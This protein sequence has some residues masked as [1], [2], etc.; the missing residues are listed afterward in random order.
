M[1][2]STHFSVLVGSGALLQHAL[3]S[4]ARGGILG[5]APFA[6][7]LAL[8][9]YASVRAGD[10]DGATQSQERLAPLHTQ[11]VSAFGVPGVKAA[12]DAIGLAGGPLRPPLHALERDDVERVARASAERGV[13]RG[14]GDTR[15]PR[16]AR[17]AR[18]R[19]SAGWWGRDE[20]G[21][22][23]LRVEASRGGLRGDGASIRVLRI[24][25]PVCRARIGCVGDA[26]GARGVCACGR[27]AAPGAGIVVLVVS[28]ATLALVAWWIAGPGVLS[29]PLLRRSGVNLECVR[30]GEA[31][32]VWLVAHIDS[33]SQPVPMFARAA[34][35]ILLVLCGG[36]ALALAIEQSTGLIGTRVWPW[37][38]VLSVLSGL[39]VMM[40]VVGRGNTGALDNASGVAA[41][42]RT[43][44]LLPPTMPIGVLFT[45]GEELALAGARAW[46][47]E[48]R[49]RRPAAVALNCDSVDD[50]GTLTVMTVGKANAGVVGAL[51]TAAR[52]AGE[53][54]RVMPLLP[55][56]LTDSV[57]FA[58]VGWRTVTLS[59]GTARTLRRI[60]SRRDTLAFLNGDGIEGAARLLANAAADLDASVSAGLE[61]APTP[62]VDSPS[63]TVDS[64]NA[65]TTARGAL[66]PPSNSHPPPGPHVLRH[67]PYRRRR[68]RAVGGRGQGKLVDVLA[69]R[70][71]W[72]VRYQGGANA[73]HTV[74]LADLAFVLHQIPSGI[75]HPGVRCAIGNGVVLDPDTL[76]TEIDGL[77]RDGIDVEGRLY[78]SDRAHLVLPYHKLVDSESPASQ[79]IG[80]TGRGIGPAYEDKVAR[81]GVRVLDLRSPTRL[82][83]L[84]E[85][86]AAHARVQLASFGS[87]KCVDVD[88]T[89]AMLEQISRRLLPLVEDV[90]ATIH[91]AIKSGAAILLEGAQGSL[92]DVDHGT[93][94]F[95]TSSSTTSGGAAIGA[96][97]APTA[98]DAVLGVVK[99]YTTRVGNGPLPT[100]F[101]A[102]LGERVRKLGNEFGAT[103]GRPRRCGWF[104]AVV[105]QYAARVNGLTDLAVTKLDVLD[106]LDRLAICTGYE[107]DGDMHTDF[108]ADVATL[109][110]ASPRYE[111]FDGWMTST[112]QARALTDLPANAR[113]Y[114]DR[115][116]ELIETPAMYVSVGTRRDQ[117]IG[118]L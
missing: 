93:Y 2:A 87:S 109:E 111:W 88:E 51:K 63:A 33:K 94:P 113:R 6:P 102:D 83:G 45:D 80:T 23:V 20:T 44:A 82:R 66:F 68:G 117:I 26:H 21:A 60:H 58:A 67:Q 3:Q 4:G 114:L 11:I 64:V 115:I 110:G 100:E 30:G 7:A 31:P 108:P 74:D 73:G 35:V 13:G 106:T 105:V 25:G 85:R 43:V 19:A 92:L 72:V 103:T 22:R 16:R 24:S 18:S 39:P 77:V 38:A 81:R 10:T 5:V 50:Q 56:V 91:R 52:A 71:D 48:Q 41:V 99:A 75:L 9:V 69:E 86:G 90:G 54:L 27:A 59:R 101:P 112:V 53:P 107:I 37:C 42:L 96:G 15:R 57:A 61:R 89:M 8:E 116:Q 55:G 1:S 84:V 104:D 65:P 47:A 78:V 76:F 46:C 70:A 62:V 40:S 14:V 95:V 17:R 118:C 98:I 32:R 29:L 36:A 34:G 97:I 12:M 28:G 79:A 49:G